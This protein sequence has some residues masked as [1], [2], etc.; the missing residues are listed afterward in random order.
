M[1]SRVVERGTIFSRR[2]FRHALSWI[3]LAGS[4]AGAWWLWPR[5]LHMTAEAILESKAVKVSKAA[6]DFILS[7]ARGSSIRLSDYRGK[8]VLLNFWATWCGPCKVEIPWFIE[9]ENA[10]RAQGFTVLGVSMDED[11][12]NVVTPYV[13]E[14]KINYPVVLGNEEVSQAYGGIVALPATMLIGRDGK[15][16]FI[17][18][19]LIEK[20]DY[21][22]EIQELLAG[23]P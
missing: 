1:E 22:K 10:W 9:F 23:R 20:A 21:R 4:I 6:P 3:V 2:I 5:A 7:D 13:A 14:K 16:A 12:W 15:I 19:G 11:G 17:H 18:S 8:V